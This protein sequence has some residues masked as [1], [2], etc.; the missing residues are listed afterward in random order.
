[1]RENEKHVLLLGDITYTKMER[2]LHEF[3]RRVTNL[4]NNI[5]FYFLN[6]IIEKNIILFI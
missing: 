3:F 2:F 5:S 4:K 6:R 1:M